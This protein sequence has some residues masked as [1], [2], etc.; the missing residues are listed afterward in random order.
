MCH[1]HSRV[2]KLTKHINW[3]TTSSTARDVAPSYVT[4]TIVVKVVKKPR[5]SGKGWMKVAR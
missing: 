2:T 5:K 4:I 3:L 1:F